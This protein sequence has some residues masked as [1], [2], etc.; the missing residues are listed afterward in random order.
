MV[1]LSSVRLRALDGVNGPADTVGNLLNAWRVERLDTAGLVVHET[2]ENLLHGGDNR[3]ELVVADTA[4]NVTVDTLGFQLPFATFLKSV[5]I[6]SS[7]RG[8][9]TCDDDHR[10]YAVGG[11]IV[12]VVDAD[13]L[14]LLA[15]VDAGASVRELQ[16]VACLLGDPILYATGVR[17]SRF[18]R[19]ALQWLPEI[20]NSFASHA[21]RASRANPALLY[22]GE[23]VVV[24]VALV[25]RI[26]VERIGSIPLPPYAF[27][28]P[29]DI[30]YDLA[31]L[32]NDARV[33][34]ARFGEDGVV[35]ADPATQQFLHRIPMGEA[36]GTVETGFVTDLALS[37]DARRLFAA[38]GLP[39][40]GI[41]LIDTERDSVITAW[42]SSERPYALALSPTGLRLFVVSADNEVTGDAGQNMVFDV[43]QGQL[44]ALLPRPKVHGSSFPEEDVVFHPNGKLIFV[45]HA[46][47][48]F[49]YLNRE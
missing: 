25:D 7:V 11:S 2:L 15:V 12:A 4:G 48:L 6:G 32:P 16:K 45:P 23:D 47:S 31:V 33:Y 20:S 17:V 14:R 44:L 28:Q 21:I 34:A 18:D 37:P 26:A 29:Y 8:V 36:V 38:V 13:S 46:T 5:L 24:S 35:V 3:I 30:V 22:V 19:V 42:F 49:V 9:A 27:P 39:Y 43:A 1:N 41:A 10:V 40:K